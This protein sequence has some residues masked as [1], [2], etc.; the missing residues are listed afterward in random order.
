MLKRFELSGG[1][2]TIESVKKGFSELKNGL[3]K[4]EL[5]LGHGTENINETE[6]KRTLD[7]RSEIDFRLE[8]FKP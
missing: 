2:S 7:S 5:G 4:T 1:H 6:K 3:Q 8:F